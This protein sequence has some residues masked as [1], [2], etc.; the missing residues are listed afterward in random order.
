MRGTLIY[1]NKIIIMSNVYAVVA[2]DITNTEYLRMPP[3]HWLK[4]ILPIKMRFLGKQRFELI[5]RSECQCI[6][7]F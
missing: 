7:F 4:N 5:T 1:K 6:V 2:F 3:S